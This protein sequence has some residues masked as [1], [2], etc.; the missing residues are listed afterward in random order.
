[1]VTFMNWERDSSCTID[2]F[3]SLLLETMKVGTHITEERL[4]ILLQRYRQDSY[5]LAKI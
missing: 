4:E 5:E 3:K 2:Q 1:M